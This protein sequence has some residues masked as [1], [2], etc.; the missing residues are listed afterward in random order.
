MFRSVP[1]FA[2]LLAGWLGGGTWYWVCQVRGLCSAESPPPVSLP[3]SPAAAAPILA[4][5]HGS[6]TVMSF[7]DPLRFLPD[8]ARPEADPALAPLLDSLAA[9][10]QAHPDLDL[11]ITGAYLTTEGSTGGLNPGLDRAAWL[12]AELEARGIAPGR[13]IKLP[14]SLTEPLAGDR[15]WLGLRLLDREVAAAAD[16]VDASAFNGRNLYFAFG[17]SDLTLDGESRAYV[18]EVIQY[19]RSH[20]A[21]TLV[22]TG[23][24][25]NV[26]DPT[27]N[28]QIGL[29]RAGTVRDYF[30]A[31]GLPAAR[32][33]TASKGDTQPIASNETDEGRSRNRRVEVSLE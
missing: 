8:S 10:L 27:R 14:R 13:F 12:A 9:Y 5:A 23:H 20:P 15:G 29:E 7:A 21:Y 3:D 11:E 33:R 30:V 25:D 24:T 17:R 6:E 18:S 26:G 4:I 16:T 2:L 22:L 31:F 32:I 1:F 28:R 19:L